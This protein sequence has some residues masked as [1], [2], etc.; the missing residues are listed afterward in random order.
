MI[1]IF[2][3]SAFPLTVLMKSRTKDGFMNLSGFSITRHLLLESSIILKVCA[4]RSK[5]LAPSDSL[6]GER[7][8]SLILVKSVFAFDKKL[9]IGHG[10]TYTLLQ[11]IFRHPRQQVG[12][13]SFIF[14]TFAHSQR[15]KILSLIKGNSKTFFFSGL[16]SKNFVSKSSKQTFEGSSHSHCIAYHQ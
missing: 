15:H 14:V 2:P 16:T 12:K 10:W 1:C 4:V 7:F 6:R 3:L 13:G 9:Q 8:A 5:Y 11:Q